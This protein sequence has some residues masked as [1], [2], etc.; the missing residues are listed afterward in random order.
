MTLFCRLLHEIRKECD[1][2][3]AYMSSDEE[4]PANQITDD[5]VVTDD[6]YRQML[7]IHRTKRKMNKVLYQAAGELT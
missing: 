2:G 4:E 6:E 7:Q 3:S 1:Q 5:T